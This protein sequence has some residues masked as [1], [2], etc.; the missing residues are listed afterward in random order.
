MI[1]AGGHSRRMGQ[2]KALLTLNSGLTLLAATVQSVQG[3]LLSADRPLASE[4]MVVTPWPERY[5]PLLPSSVRLV[6]EPTTPSPA[7]N[8]DSPGPLSGFAYGWTQITSEWCLLLACDLPY[9]NAAELARWWQSIER[10]QQETS[11]AE[12]QLIQASL[13]RSE[14]GWE[15]LC[16]FYHRSCQPS[17]ATY[18]AGAQRSFQG[19]LPGLSVSEYTSAPAQMFFNCNRPEDWQALKRDKSL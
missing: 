9:L 13:A 12:T 19:W 1:L 2:D 5:E 16:G 10:E 7:I 6:K 11:A 18:L 17:L 15:P 4:V 14:K 3:Q 8:H